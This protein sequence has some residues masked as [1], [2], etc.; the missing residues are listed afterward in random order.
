MNENNQ[1]N[2][3]LKEILAEKVAI[4]ERLKSTEQLKALYEQENL[5]VR[6]DMNLLR[7]TMQEAVSFTK[8]A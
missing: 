7:K 5:K 1:L 4:A 3:K 8:M 2:Q 6:N